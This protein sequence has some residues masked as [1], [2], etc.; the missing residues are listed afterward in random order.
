MM[1]LNTAISIMKVEIKNKYAQAYLTDISGAIE[2]GG[3]Y[4]LKIQ[5][6]YVLSNASNWR[7]SQATEVKSYIRQWIKDK[8]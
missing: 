2:N 3:T 4:G 8:S 7:G 6:E 1:D 5:L